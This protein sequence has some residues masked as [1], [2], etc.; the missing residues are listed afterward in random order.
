LFWL[1]A[2]VLSIA[3]NGSAFA[4]NQGEFK[5][6]KPPVDPK[7]RRKKAGDQEYQSTLKGDTRPATEKG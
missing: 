3:P 4:Q 7:V 5:G 1:L 6:D 2:A